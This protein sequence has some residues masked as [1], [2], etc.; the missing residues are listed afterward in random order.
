[1]PEDGTLMGATSAYMAR[2]NRANADFKVLIS[3]EEARE[4]VLALTPSPDCR[5]VDTADVTGARRSRPSG[6]RG[7][8]EHALHVARTPGQKKALL[9]AQPAVAP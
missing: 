6:S 3:G 9:A 8:E 7:A 2:A 5:V 4:V 1:M